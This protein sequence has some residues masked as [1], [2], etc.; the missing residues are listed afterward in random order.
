MWGKKYPDKKETSAGWRRGCVGYGNKKTTFQQEKST[1]H[2]SKDSQNSDTSQRTTKKERGNEREEKDK[3]KS[4]QKSE[5]KKDEDTR[6]PW[7]LLLLI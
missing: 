2:T 3:I 6:A 7:K 1:H 4:K 5:E